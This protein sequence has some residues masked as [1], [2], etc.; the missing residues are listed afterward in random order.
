MFILVL[1]NGY[2]AQFGEA[3]PEI[4]FGTSECWA[5]WNFHKQTAKD[6]AITGLAWLRLEAVEVPTH[7]KE[8]RLVCN[9]NNQFLSSI[10][11][12]NC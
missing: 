3:L 5:S 8:C 12:K 4:N 11:H 9:Q 6:G 10:L 7:Y 1:T 2:V